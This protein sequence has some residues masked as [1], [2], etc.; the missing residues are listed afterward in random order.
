MTNTHSFSSWL[1]VREKV[2]EKKML[3]LFLLLQS[4]HFGFSVAIDLWN[5][6]LF[7]PVLPFST[8]SCWFSFVW[9]NNCEWWRLPIG[10]PSSPR[11][12]QG[13]FMLDTVK[14]WVNVA[15]KPSA[16]T[17][18]DILYCIELSCSQVVFLSWVLF[19][20]RALQTKKAS[21]FAN[22][23]FLMIVKTIITAHTNNQIIFV[24]VV[25]FDKHLNDFIKVAHN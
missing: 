13:F 1:L 9:K 19:A 8:V 6:I 7:I 20:H 21:P 22:W 23:F 2:Y 4:N 3:Q 18:G 24:S 25:A 14:F 12:L 5:S 16:L 17:D 15:I 10:E 11:V